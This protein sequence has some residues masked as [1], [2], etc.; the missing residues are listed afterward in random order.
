MLASGD[1][2]DSFGT[3]VTSSLNDFGFFLYYLST[4][5]TLSISPNWI[6]DVSRTAIPL[7]VEKKRVH[8]VGKLDVQRN[9]RWSDH[10]SWQW[11]SSREKR[12]REIV[13]LAMYGGIDRN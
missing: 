11:S 9:A 5:T 10:S 12:K 1:F 2:V 4:K 7:S 8:R 6:F 13:K 3:S